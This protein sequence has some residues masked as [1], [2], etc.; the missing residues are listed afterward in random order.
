LIK[1]LNKFFRRNS[2]QS[3]AEF[4]VITAMMATFLATAS[5]KLSDMMEGGK[6]RKVEEEMDKILV[7]AQNFY[8]ETS[9][10]EGR[11]RFPGQDKYNM[12]VGGYTTEL[13]LINDLENFETYDDQDGKNWC[14]I[15]GISHA[16]ASMPSGALFVNDTIAAVENCNACAETRYAGHDDWLFKFGGN[17]LPSPFQDGH[18]IYVVI[19]G[20]GTG[21]NAEPPILYIADAEN[22]KYLNKL[23]QF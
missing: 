2:G 16:E 13:D 14:S 7:Q 4:A 5:G 20:S 22:P 8:Q 23:L 19:P 17:A 9:T 18:F 3:L 12:R 10:Q 1:K 15:F 11:G 21:E 6:V